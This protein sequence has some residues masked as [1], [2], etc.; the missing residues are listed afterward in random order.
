MGLTQAARIKINA[1]HGHSHL[2][3]PPS[4]TSPAATLVWQACWFHQELCLV[5]LLGRLLTATFTPCTLSVIH[6]KRLLQLH[7]LVMAV[8]IH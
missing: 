3:A 6:T 7:P 5:R 4:L 8:D 2:E 1:P